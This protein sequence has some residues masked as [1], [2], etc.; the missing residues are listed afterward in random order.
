[1]DLLQELLG[2]IPLIAVALVVLALVILWALSKF[3]RL[4]AN[5]AIKEELREEIRFRLFDEQMEAEAKVAAAA[6]DAKETSVA[7]PEQNQNP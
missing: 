2:P 1:M 7:E 3:F 6:T 4:P 5:F